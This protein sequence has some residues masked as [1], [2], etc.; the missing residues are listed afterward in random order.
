MFPV[1]LRSIEEQEGVYLRDLFSASSLGFYTE[2]H[3][4]HATVWQVSP[5][6]SPSWSPTS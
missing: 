5:E 3:F 1:V 4:V 2:T 6:A